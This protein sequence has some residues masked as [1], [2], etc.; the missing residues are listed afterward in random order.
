[1][2]VPPS[3]IEPEWI[4]L[5][6]RAARTLLGRDDRTGD[7]LAREVKL[8][9][10]IYTR[11]RTSLHR[12]SVELAARLRFFFLR[13]LPKIERP[14]V[15][16]ALAPRP[17]LRVLDLG[18]GL[19]TSTMGIARVAKRTGLAER[20]EV[21]AVEHAPRLVDVMGWLA[22]RAGE[23]AVPVTLEAR[24]ADLET[25]DPRTLP[26]DVDVI[27]VGLALNELF[28]DRA[29][30]I[31]ARAEWLRAVSACLG[32]DGVLIVLEPAL[33]ETTRALM[34]VRDRLAGDAGLHVLAP[35]TAEGACPMLRRERDWCHADDALGLPEPLAGL[36][37]AAGLRWEGLTYAYLVLGRRPRES[38][39]HRVVGGP[40]VQKGRTEWHVCRAPA[41]ARLAV[42]HRDRDETERLSGLVRGSRVRL[43]PEPADGVTIRAGSAVEVS[44]VGQAG[45]SEPRS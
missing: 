30:P 7:A 22:D 1:M 19:G 20:L 36:A 44:V 37:R 12:T 41:L 18:A 6:D 45:G 26:T 35:C 38:E 17:T 15:E 25:L 27:V 39:C 43:R 40:I 21:V 23:V 28:I 16:L 10:E 8:V 5:V 31:A 4:A 33:R 2:S 9:S 42:L 32:P 29:D 14:L 13:D 24:E 11:N 3:S 34:A